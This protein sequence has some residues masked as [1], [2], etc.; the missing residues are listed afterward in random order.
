MDY[1]KIEEEESPQALR[2]A[3]WINR[4]LNPQNI[5][6]IGCATGFYLFPF[7]NINPLGID[8]DENDQ[9]RLFTKHRKYS[10][11]EL[12][13]FDLTRSLKELSTL[14]RYDVGIC[15]EVAEHIDEKFENIFMDNIVSLCRTLIFSAAPPRQT[16]DGHIN[17]KAKAYWLKQFERRG[18]LY[19][20]FESQAMLG[21]MQQGAHMGWFV[22]NAFIVS[23]RY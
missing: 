8:Y 19:D 9:C 10:E 5:V 23:G 4:E 3:R 6:D 21:Y 14:D 22:N 1:K 18:M 7:K 15:L 20:A 17:L 12:L 16:G 11:I 13:N 2:L